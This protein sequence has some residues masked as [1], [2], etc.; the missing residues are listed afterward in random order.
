MR[1]TSR[2]TRLCTNL[3]ETVFE[4]FKARATVPSHAPKDDFEHLKPIFTIV[5]KLLATSTQII[6]HCKKDTVAME[7]KLSNVFKLP[8]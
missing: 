2:L 1:Y 5:N 7:N 3:E 8:Q 4:V 6:H